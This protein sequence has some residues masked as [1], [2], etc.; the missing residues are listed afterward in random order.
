MMK[1]SA[2]PAAFVAISAFSCSSSDSGAPAA[3]PSSGGA[4]SGTQGGAAGATGGST[5]AS[6][7]GAR[8]TGGAS[9]GAR[10]KD[11]G[12]GGSVQPFE[13]G[14]PAKNPCVE[15]GTC[16]PGV[17][18][19]VT[20]PGIDFTNQLDCGNYG[21]ETIAAD[22]KKPGTFYTV[23]M[24]QGIWKTDD[25]G[26]TW[27]G[28]INTG[29][30][31]A[32]AGDCAGGIT[33]P[34][35]NPTS[36]PTIYEACIRGNGAGFWRSTN[37]GVDWTRYDV[38][39]G[40]ARQDYYPPVVDPYDQN[41]LV[42]PGHEMN[43]LVESVDGGQTWTAVNTDPGMNQNGGTAEVFFIDTGDPATTRKTLLWLGQ[44]STLYGTWRTADGGGTWK[45]VDKNE[46]PH[47][48]SQIFQPDA[49]G[50]VYMAGAYSTF[51]W[52]VLRSADYGQTWAHVGNTGGEA[53]VFGTSKFVYAELSG[54]IGL[55][56]SQD[57][58]FELSPEPGTGTWT[59][60]GTPAAMK[61]GAA[62][63]AVANDGQHNVIL[64]ANW[65]YGVWRYIEP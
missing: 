5:M 61:L 60:P 52:G 23:F 50:V 9:G 8:A 27:T 28:P 4:D 1:H 14:P 10:S 41:H 20:P 47:G 49:N 59:T 48:T 51:G 17:W 46:H 24:C 55:G 12:S 32:A 35:R 44:Q 64:T 6:T 40:G 39:P 34:P 58:S 57:P 45:Q 15:N 22:A 2:L 65:G 30:Q 16:P 11:G 56:G 33:I 31:S 36:P 21:T 37:G 43:V 42:M 53:V 13:A 18:I 63:A 29:S 62:Q 19:D 7:G 54:A 26:Q 3:N 25:Y 38:A